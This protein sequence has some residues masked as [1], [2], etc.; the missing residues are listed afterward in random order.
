[1]GARTRIK[2]LA[3]LLPEWT[4]NYTKRRPITTYNPT[5]E[6]TARHVV[7]EPVYTMFRYSAGQ[8]EERHVSFTEA[9]DR[10]TQSDTITWLNVDGLNKGEVEKLCA[11][12][13][14]HP[15]TVEDILSIGQR[16]KMEE[17]PEIIFCLLPMLYY[18]DGTGQIETEQVSI[19]LGKNF[20]ISFQE[21][22]QRDVF[23]PVRDRLRSAQPKLRARQADY[24]CYSLID[25]I[26]DS[27]FGIID[28]I[29]E[30]IERLEDAL[31]LQKE[32]T[33]LARISILRRE[34]MVM[35]RSIAPVRELVNAFIRSDS[36][37][38]EERHEKYYKDVYDHIVQATEYVENHRDMLMN[39]QDLSMSQINL[40]M[41]EIMKVF[42]LLATLMAPATVIGGIFGMNFDIIPLAHHAMGFYA[43]V[44]I[45]LAVPLLMLIW[46]KRKGWF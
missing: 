2:G 5:R 40:R 23:D 29:N 32:N 36:D 4:W 27:Y 33:A 9:C 35:R 42:T 13:N 41:N 7:V 19:I 14:I 44:A 1:M 46:F 39:L 12:Y 45:M 10:S 25:I 8:L 21:D 15:L 43:T 28:K 16:A 18:N 38:L 6:T 31:L 3:K 17:S 34:I 11:C 20:V 22:P 26:V 24:L 37:L 30:R